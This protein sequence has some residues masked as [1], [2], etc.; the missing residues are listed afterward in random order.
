MPVYEY[1]CTECSN[2]FEILMRDQKE[3]VLCP[4]CNS[5]KVSKL[6]STFAHRRNTSSLEGIQSRSN[7]SCSSCSGGNCATCH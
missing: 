3:S 4:Q 6:F 1:L 7:S 2:E 5:K